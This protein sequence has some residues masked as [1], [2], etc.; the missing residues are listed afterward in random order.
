VHDRFCLH[1]HFFNNILN[2]SNLF[3]IIINDHLPRANGAIRKEH[4]SCK[5]G[6]SPSSTQ[7][8]TSP[9]AQGISQPYSPSSESCSPKANTQEAP[10]PPKLT[11]LLIVYCKKK[12]KKYCY[13]GAFSP[14]SVTS[15][16]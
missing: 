14:F 7:S 4:I 6:S 8:P 2:A 9:N 15:N 12:Q 10:S 16:S 13:Y 11:L 3:N 5:Y 1:C